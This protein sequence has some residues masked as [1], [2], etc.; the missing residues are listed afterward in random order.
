MHFMAGG[1]PVSGRYG[2]ERA[3]GQQVVEDRSNAADPEA[4]NNAL[5]VEA[6][7]AREVEEA[8]RVP[9]V[10]DEERL[11]QAE[12]CRHQTRPHHRLAMAR[13]CHVRAEPREEERA[14]PHQ[15][16]ILVRHHASPISFEAKG[17]LSCRPVHPKP[18]PEICSIKARWS[19]LRL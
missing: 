8:R 2:Q 17:G 18:S 7:P 15:P 11:G 5:D 1:M 10:W 9:V 14:R 4:E 13:K 16:D 6:A 12:R 3:A 19:P